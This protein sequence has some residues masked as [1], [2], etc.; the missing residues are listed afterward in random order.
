VYSFQSY[1][2]YALNFER[3]YKFKSE[4]LGSTSEA[5]KEF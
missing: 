4:A 2:A 5:K 1:Q 3:E